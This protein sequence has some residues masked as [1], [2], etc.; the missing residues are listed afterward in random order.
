MDAPGNPID[1]KDASC[2]MNASLSPYWRGP[3]PDRN[4]L[5]DYFHFTLKDKQED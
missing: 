5:S 4:W 3:F 1:L 2:R